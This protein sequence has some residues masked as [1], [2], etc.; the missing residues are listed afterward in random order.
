LATTGNTL[1]GA[2]YADIYND[3]GFLN[4]S[5]QWRWRIDNSGV[6]QQGG[7]PWARVTGAP[8]FVTSS[9]VTSVATGTGLTGGTITSSGTIT[10]LHATSSAQGGIRIRVSGSTLFI[11]ND[12][13]NA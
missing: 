3:I 2:I 4:T 13:N 7:V 8:A 1:R 6:L 11:R 12:G 10:L 5:G 9:G